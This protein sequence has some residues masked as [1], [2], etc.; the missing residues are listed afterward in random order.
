MTSVSIASET[1]ALTPRAMLNKVPQVTLYF[2]VIKILATTVGETFADFLALHISPLRGAASV[3]FEDKL[4]ARAELSTAEYNDTLITAGLTR[5]MIIA[6][7]F[8]AVVLVFQFMARTYVPAIYWLAVVAMSV[9]GTL[10]TDNIVENYGVSKLTMAIVFAVLLAITFAVWFA[11]EKTLSIHSITTV[12]REIFYWLTILF[13]FALGTAAGDYL[14][15]TTEMGYWK[16]A[17]LF[18]GMIAAI[19]AA[20]VIFKKQNSKLDSSVLAFW[21]AYIITR[22]LGASIGDLLSQPKDSD[23][24]AERGLGLGTTV[25][26]LIF[27]SVIL[28]VVVFMSVTKK[29]ATPPEVSA[30]V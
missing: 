30:S 28:A 10:V 5:M 15:E 16:A 29:D 8:L 20:H 13:T 2:W 23:V 12:K 25:T 7:I 4:T 14:A 1:K 17:L 6:G 22:P 3:M 27:L 9:F 18:A 26:S 11:S 19:Y 21:A 24:V